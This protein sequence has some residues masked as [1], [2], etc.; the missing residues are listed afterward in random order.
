MT[1]L[2]YHPGDKIGPLNIILKERDSS[3]IK[4]G[5]FVCPYCGKEFL[6]SIGNIKTG[7][8]KSCGCSTGA[9]ISDKLNKDISGQR[10][11]N[12]IAV[13]SLKKKD[14]GGHTL[15][16]CVCD[17]GKTCEVTI[18][19]L[20]TGNTKSCGD[21]YNC[22]YAYANAGKRAIDISG[23]RFGKLVA[24]KEKY[25]KDKQVYWECI[26]DCG[27][28]TIKSVRQL[29][30]WGVQSCGCLKSKGE[31]IITKILQKEN[32]DFI[33]QKTFDTCRN[34][35]TNYLLTFDFYLP[36]YNT[37][38]EYNGIQHYKETGGWSNSEKLKSQQYRDS[39][40]YNWCRDNG[41][42]LEYIKYSENIEDK[43]DKIL[44][45]TA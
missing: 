27:N 7:N 6:A 12:L 45:S 8:T 34:P 20:T 15:W 38:I 31:E 40:K 36:E 18:N 11:G 23:Q 19:N 37:C 28:M 21:I 39:I 16:E 14:G 22:K 17:C 9:I 26:C 32:I 30:A 43:L 25:R 13:K 3:N 29:K 33:T 1:K 24:I 42:R 2:K 10:F 41:I 35:K 44:N 5:I 4:K